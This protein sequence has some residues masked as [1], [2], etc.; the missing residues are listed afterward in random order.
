MSDESKEALKLIAECD[1]P[2]RAALTAYALLID[3]LKHREA[4]KGI[5]SSTLQVIAPTQLSS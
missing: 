5:S 3:F 2:E 4:S 1:D